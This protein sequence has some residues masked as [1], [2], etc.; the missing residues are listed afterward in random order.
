MMDA[1]QLA[2]KML[3]WETKRKEL[4]ALGAEITDA[5]LAIGKT[6]TVGNVRASYSDG[7]RT[8]DHEYPVQMERRRAL[9]EDNGDALKEIDYFIA[10]NTVVVSS[11]SWRVVREALKLE[12]LCTGKS[13]PSVTLKLVE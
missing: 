3:D 8:F 1:S 11:T 6:Q 12:P 9:A 4:D 5:V 13:S 10:A 7:R 2:L